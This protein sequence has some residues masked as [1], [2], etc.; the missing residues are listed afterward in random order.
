M[1]KNNNSDVIVD[2]LK[3]FIRKGAATTPV[4]YVPT[5][6]FSLDFAINY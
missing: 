1:A 2:N 6:H 5:G 3:G 4:G